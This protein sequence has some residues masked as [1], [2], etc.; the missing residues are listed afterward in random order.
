MNN[1]ING[2][3]FVFYDQDSGLLIKRA[4]RA[5]EDLK[6][7]FPDSIDLKVSNK[8]NIGCAFC[9]E[10]STPKGKLFDFS[11]TTEIL[12]QLPS[13]PIEI[14]IGGGDVLENPE[15]I[16]KLIAW[17]KERGH[18]PR[19]TVNWKSL[20]KLSKEKK[21]LLGSVDGI[22][23]SID[24]LPELTKEFPWDT[25]SSIY[26]T[27]L[28]M[29]DSK[30]LRI[31]IRRKFVIHIIAGIFPINQ[32]AELLSVCG[33]DNM[34]VLILGYKSFGRGKIAPPG[35]EK[36]EEFE[37]TI[38]QLLYKWRC[39]ISGTI[40][41]DN[42][43]LE[44]LHIKDSLTDFEWNQLYMGEEG[45]HSMYIDAVEGKFA[46]TSMSD[47]RVSWDSVGLIDYFKSL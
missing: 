34:A 3:Y 41:F 5:G 8:C 12:S 7:E 40:G 45:K 44:Q 4:K 21:N 13:A 39:E 36:L 26:Y 18:R 24:H 22:G 30:E 19:I 31:S 25:E 16:G 32:L 23:I 27:I 47:S 46:R 42:L 11:K 10:S 15:E 14:A 17:L 9:H 1:Y 29:V 2:N 6:A 33:R 20:E 37:R 35:I 28:N 38:K 43:A